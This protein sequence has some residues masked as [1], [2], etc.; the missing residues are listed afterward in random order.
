[1][2]KIWY[3]LTTP[4]RRYKDRQRLKRIKEEMRQRDPFIYQ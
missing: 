2:S 4:Y 3:W 1:M